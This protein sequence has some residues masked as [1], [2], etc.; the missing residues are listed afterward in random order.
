MPAHIAGNATTAAEMFEG[1]ARD[2]DIPQ[3][4]GSD[5]RREAEIDADS[6]RPAAAL[7]ELV[8][9]TDARCLAAYRAMPDWDGRAPGVTVP[10][11]P[12]PLVLAWLFGRG[13]PGLPQLPAWADGGNAVHSDAQ[14]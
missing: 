3:Y 5:L 12:A 2:E 7:A 9:D 10:R 14:M 1:Y 13:D 11:L 8:R 4:G 6:S